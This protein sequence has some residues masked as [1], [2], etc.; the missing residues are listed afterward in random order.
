MIEILA[1]LAVPLSA[2]TLIQLWGLAT[3]AIGGYLES[4]DFRM[5]TPE[6]NFATL[7]FWMFITAR[8]NP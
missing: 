2:F 3:I 1:S 5:P 8:E 6:E 7:P 4:R